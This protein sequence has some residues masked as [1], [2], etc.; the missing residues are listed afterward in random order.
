MLHWRAEYLAARA[1]GVS[2]PGPGEPI[3]SMAQAL[4]AHPAQPRRH[5]GR[6]G[7]GPGLRSAP[8]APP[9]WRAP[10][11]LGIVA[12][13]SRLG[14]ALGEPPRVQA[15]AKARAAVFARGPMPP[16]APPRPA[17]ALTT[18][19]HALR[20]IAAL[21]GVF[22]AAGVDAGTALLAAAC[23]RAFPRGARVLDLGCGAGQAALP[24]IAALTAWRAAS[25]LL[26][27][28]DARAVASAQANLARLELGGRG[29]AQWW[30]AVRGLAR[31]GVR[32]GGGESA[33]RAP[34]RGGRSRRRAGHC[35]ARCR[36]PSA[37]VAPRWWWRTRRLPYELRE[38]GAASARAVWR[39]RGTGTRSSRRG[40]AEAGI[41]TVDRLD[42][43]LAHR[44]FG[45]RSQ[46]RSLVKSGVVA[47]AGVV[48]RDQAARVEGR[49][50][51]V[52]GPADRGGRVRG[53]PAVSPADRLRLQQRLRAQRRF[54]T[55][56]V[57]P[58]LS[59]LGLQGAGAARPRQQRPDG[60][61]HRRRAHPHPHQPATACAQA[62]PGRLQR[63]PLPPRGC[64]LREGHAPARRSQADAAPRARGP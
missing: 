43:F 23:A 18:Q 11:C 13:I 21:P 47:L 55:D 33:A 8:A 25:A 6:P 63:T 44:G 51:T 5:R 31:A 3:P 27:D 24:A 7:G 61:L 46:V 19:P 41:P 64:A 15:R 20:A 29:R 32:P 10:N 50:V 62:L 35:C 42:A 34:W 22:G 52:Q 2:A 58:E 1:A 36:A 38:L 57:P 40:A 59:H 30:D 49:A 45:T 28:A 37:R 53:H 14:R 39:W 26:L 16:P 12:W 9:R 17:L 60:A 56:L 54:L 48:C 4:G